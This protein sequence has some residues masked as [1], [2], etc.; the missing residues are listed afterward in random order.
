MKSLP[1]LPDIMWLG[2]GVAG[3]RQ[4]SACLI[5]S[6][7]VESKSIPTSPNRG[8][9]GIRRIIKGEPSDSTVPVAK[10]SKLSCREIPKSDRNRLFKIFMLSWA[11]LLEWR[12]CITMEGLAGSIKAPS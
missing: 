5:L 4:A 2:N 6:A 3:E 1:V 10:K 8:K 9:A 12:T 7:V 11:P